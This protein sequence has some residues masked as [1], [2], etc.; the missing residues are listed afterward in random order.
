[1]IPR[2][3]NLDHASAI[4][5]AE[6]E[7]GRCVAVLRDLEPAD[8]TRPT[9]C[10]A[11]DVRQLACHMLGMVEMVASVRELARQQRKAARAGGDPLDALTG[12]QVDERR[13]SSPAA[14]VERFGRPGSRVD[15]TA[16]QGLHPCPG[17]AGWWSLDGGRER[18]DAAPRRHRVLPS[19]VGPAD[20]DRAGRPVQHQR[21]LLTQGSV[22]QPAS[23][24]ASNQATSRSSLPASRSSSSVCNIVNFE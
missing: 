8:W 20:L 9:D 18:S 14:I 21:S 6:V 4:R 12:L 15:K 13:E 17:R 3:S 24:A 16:R 22:R 1:M 2:R 5:L 10:S 11:W 19:A 23:S 7:Y